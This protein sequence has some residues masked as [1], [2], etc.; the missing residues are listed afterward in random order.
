MIVVVYYYLGRAIIFIKKLCFEFFKI[1][2]D[3][4]LEVKVFIIC[5]YI[6]N[7]YIYHVCINHI[8][9]SYLNIKPVDKKNF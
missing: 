1:N 2:L 9:S 8:M 6:S 7:K 3:I 4:Y 5:N